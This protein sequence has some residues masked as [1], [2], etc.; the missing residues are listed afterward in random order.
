MSIGV[1]VYGSCNNNCSGNGVCSF[2]M[3]SCYAGYTGND[4][5]IGKFVDYYYC[6]YLCTFNQGTCGLSYIE[7][8]NRYF[9]C[10]CFTGY[11][12]ATCSIAICS[13]KCNYA[14]KCTAP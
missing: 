10:T 8:N 2:G 4:C 9:N 6:G 13:S 7:G 12:G 14:G 5:S 3:C 11:T 1:Q